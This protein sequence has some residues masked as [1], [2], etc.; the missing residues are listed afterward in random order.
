MKR[1]RSMLSSTVFGLLSAAVVAAA[2][3]DQTETDGA[4]PPETRLPDNGDAA[5]ATTDGGDGD[6][7]VNPGCEAS[8]TCAPPP[9][10]CAA[11]DFCAVT[12]PMA[13]DVVLNGIWGSSAT[14]I[15]AVGSRGTILH[16]NG[17]TFSTVPSGTNVAL[18][19][20]F[21][22][23]SDDVWI[24]ASR[25]PLHSKAL[26]DGG[27][28]WESVQGERWVDDLASEGRTWTLWGSSKDAIWMGGAYSSR[29]G[30]PGSFWS[31]GTSEDGGVVWNAETVYRQFDTSG[32]DATIRGIWGAGPNDVWGVGQQGYI[33]RYEPASQETPAR[34]LAWDSQTTNTL[35]GIWGSSTSDIW[36]VGSVGTI[37]HSTGAPSTF[38]VV[39]SPTSLALHAVWGSSPNDVWI[40][41]DEGTLLHW[42]GTAWSIADAG[43]PPGSRPN[44]Y[45]IWGTGPND[46]WIVGE[47]VILHRTTQNRNRP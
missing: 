23:A 41:G 4:A 33:F 36:I 6:V 19:S 25:A 35:E 10:D 22:T 43:L 13:S 20:V 38:D 2:C 21:G 45:G 28:E 39:N 1:H 5:G 16:G 12:A 27:L 26:P 3:A 30:A 14:D 34:W 24:A 7:F 15:W 42:D 37:R 32:W 46:V 29:F 17:N 31:K 11:V 47:G 18:F 40:V 44:L 9:V 8:N